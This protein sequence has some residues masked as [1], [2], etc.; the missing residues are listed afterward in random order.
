MILTY[1]AKCIF[2]LSYSILISLFAT[3]ITFVFIEGYKLLA[4][5]QWFWQFA[6]G[7]F[8]RLVLITI[9]YLSLFKITKSGLKKI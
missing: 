5:K 8:E 9:Y 7:S 6:L 1:K 2:F 4:Q 3:N